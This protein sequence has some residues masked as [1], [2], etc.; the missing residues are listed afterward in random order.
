MADNQPDPKPA[1]ELTH[2]FNALYVEA[3]LQLE[4]GTPKVFLMNRLR[5]DRATLTTYTTADGENFYSAHNPY[6]LQH[7]IEE[8]E[9]PDELSCQDL[10]LI[11]PQ[12]HALLNLHR[13]KCDHLHEGH[14]T[15][16]LRGDCFKCGLENCEDAL[17]LA[18]HTP[19]FENDDFRSTVCIC[20]DCGEKATVW[21]EDETSRLPGHSGVWADCETCDTITG[22]DGVLCDGCGEVNENYDPDCANWCNAECADLEA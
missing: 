19:Q 11:L 22:H 17:Q 3:S 2:A 15:V 16:S 12:V 14:P 10:H 6:T 5:N 20:A 8:A 21:I 13:A 9:A 4:G 7:L 1:E 18:H